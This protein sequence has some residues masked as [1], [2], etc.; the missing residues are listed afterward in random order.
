MSRDSYKDRV[1]A[2]TNP[3]EGARFSTRKN[4]ERHVRFKGKPAKRKDIVHSLVSHG[5][6]HSPQIENAFVEVSVAV[7]WIWAIFTPFSMIWPSSSAISDTTQSDPFGNCSQPLCR[8][9]SL[10]SGMKGVEFKTSR[11]SGRTVS[12]GT[13][14]DK[15]RTS[16]GVR[17]S[18]G[19]YPVRARDNGRMGGMRD[20]L[21]RISVSRKQY[22]LQ[23][24][25]SHFASD[26]Q[27][28]PFRR[29]SISRQ[30]FV[31]HPRYQ[32]FTDSGVL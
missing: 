22:D 1:D 27:E 4:K 28:N 30:S 7:G 9:S 19:P 11:E 31:R 15:T 21:A 13:S 23:N 26:G 8:S 5:I 29:Q 24:K 20:C 6:L 16:F 12:I 32:L 10:D 18:D 3:E 17:E 25:N 2:K 14:S